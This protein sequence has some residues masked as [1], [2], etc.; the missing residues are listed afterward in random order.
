M[1]KR[2]PVPTTENCKTAG[3]TSFQGR[4]PARFLESQGKTTAFMKIFRK[5]FLISMHVQCNTGQT[6]WQRGISQWQRISLICN[7]D[8][9][10][11]RIVSVPLFFFLFEPCFR[12]LAILIISPIQFHFYHHHPCPRAATSTPPAPEPLP[13]PPHTSHTINYCH[14]L[15]Q[16]TETEL[17]N[18]TES[19]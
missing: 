9:R 5:H 3:C 8:G 10:G 11:C 2:A 17:I 19:I 7:K 13:L 6:R 16:P 15:P 14:C 18:T 1:S 4:R 12:K